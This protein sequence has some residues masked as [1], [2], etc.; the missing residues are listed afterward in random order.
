MGAQLL[1]VAPDLLAVIEL[2]SPLVDGGA[3]H[4][5]AGHPA[6]GVMAALD[7]DAEPVGEGVVAT[8]VLA[9]GVPERP[10]PI[11]GRVDPALERI[12]GGPLNGALL[13]CGGGSERH[14]L[15]A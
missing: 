3:F 5:G 2:D 13:T 1:V 14:D 12:T 9:D 6:V 4:D 7:V 11:G 8:E 15:S 10:G